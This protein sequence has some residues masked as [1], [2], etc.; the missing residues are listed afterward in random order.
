MSGDGFGEGLLQSLRCCVVV[1]PSIAL[2]ALQPSLK[3]IVPVAVERAIRD[4]ISAVV[5][6]SGIYIYIDTDSCCTY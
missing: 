4:I 1:S 6:R 3:A 2:F 5:E